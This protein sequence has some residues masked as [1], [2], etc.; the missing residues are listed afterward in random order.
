[1]AS[2]TRVHSSCMTCELVCVCVCA[3]FICGLFKRRGHVYMHTHTHSYILTYIHKYT[4]NTYIRTHTHAHIATLKC[5]PNVGFF[6]VWPLQSASE[7]SCPIYILEF[8][9]VF[10]ALCS[11]IHVRYFYMHVLLCQQP[12]DWLFAGVHTAYVTRNFNIYSFVILHFL[13]KN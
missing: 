3:L 7:L 13:V 6:S 9:S 5:A 11:Y 1:V 4:H 8:S 2:D 10:A 12:I